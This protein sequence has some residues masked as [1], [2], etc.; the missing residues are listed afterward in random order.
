MLSK[1]KFQLCLSLLHR[2]VGR[3]VLAQT[4]GVMRVHEQHALMHQRGETHRIPRTIEFVV[5]R[6]DTAFSEVRRLSTAIPGIDIVSLARIEDAS[7]DE[8]PGLIADDLLAEL[9]EERLHFLAVSLGFGRVGRSH[10]RNAS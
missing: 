6:H 2:L 3:P 4:D 5:R 9:G 1:V 8:L 10:G 7:S